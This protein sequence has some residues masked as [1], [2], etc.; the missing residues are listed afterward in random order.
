MK[1]IRIPKREVSQRRKERKDKLDSIEHYK[2][3][4]R[5][6]RTMSTDRIM[7]INRDVT[8]L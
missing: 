4:S 2:L 3:T 1:T 5:R 6:G 7:R 8:Y